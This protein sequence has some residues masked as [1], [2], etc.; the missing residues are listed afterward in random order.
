MT[1]FFPLILD[2]KMVIVGNLKVTESEELKVKT[3][4]DPSSR[5]SS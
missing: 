3:T 4:C 1:C 2:V 5:D